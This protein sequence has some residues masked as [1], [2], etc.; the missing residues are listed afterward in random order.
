MPYIQT[1]QKEYFTD[2][3]KLLGKEAIASPGELNFLL[4]ELLKQYMVT[5]TK[6]YQ[7]YNDMVGAL[8]S[9][10]LELY[11]R[12]IAPYEDEKIESNGDVYTQ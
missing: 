10:K 9:C 8:E 12:L 6:N 4:T 5:R 3:L 1:A 11:R 7:C 2:L